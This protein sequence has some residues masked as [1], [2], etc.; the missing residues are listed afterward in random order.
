MDFTILT[1][2]EIHFLEGFLDEEVY[3]GFSK[4]RCRYAICASEDGVIYGA[5][6]FD[7]RKTIIVADICVV[8]KYRGKLEKDLIHELVNLQCG[9]DCNGIVMD[10]FDSAYGNDLDHVLMNEGLVV[11][12]HS[13][14]YRFFLKNIWK[15]RSISEVRSRVGIISLGET[16]DKQKR[17]F[18]DFLK[19]ESLF[20]RLFDSEIS[21]TLS[22]VYV[23][24]G[25]ILGC[26]LVS[27]L[28]EESF[29]LEFVY[30]DTENA[31]LYALPAM[32]AE[33]AASLEACY[34]DVDVVGYTLT[35]NDQADRLM[36]DLLPDAE[37][38]DF[39]RRFAG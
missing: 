8:P 38:I 36:T 32:L 23:K 9:L 34:P 3:L 35:T 26:V 24:D 6:V 22:K 21:N 19:R 27:L 29:C 12:D 33:A 13:T 10:V 28:D 14:L 16:S 31:Q 37:I 30:I 15:N 4:I 1:G 39:C 25:Q 11:A 20:D 2:D 5:I 17:V 7:A 18:S